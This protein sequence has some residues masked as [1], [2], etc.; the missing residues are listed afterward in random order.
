[1]ETPDIQH[2]FLQESD[3]LDDEESL[4]GNDE[5][6]SIQEHEEGTSHAQA[7]AATIWNTETNS[8]GRNTITCYK[9]EREGHIAPK[10]IHT[11][12]ID[13][14]PIGSRSYGPIDTGV[15][16]V[17]DAMIDNWDEGIDDSEEC[18]WAFAQPS[19]KSN[20]IK[21]KQTTVINKVQ[22]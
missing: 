13:D 9:Y 11:T 4:E 7:D 12:T 3:T 14:K 22:G 17:T 6:C 18:A 19:S 1:M 5:D 20:N 8:G 15:T 10:C 21:A 2:S 16:L